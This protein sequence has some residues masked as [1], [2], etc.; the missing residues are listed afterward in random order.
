[1]IRLTLVSNALHLEAARRLHQLAVAAD[2]SDGARVDLLIWEPRRM[3]LNAEDRR[4]WPLRLPVGSLVLAV[5]VPVALAGKVG[6]MRLPHLRHAGRALRLIAAH[7]RQLVLIDDGL[8][9]YRGI[10]KA[11]APDHFP[12]GTAY[13]LFSDAP[14]AR[15]S[16]C[17]RFSCRELGP[18]YPAADPRQQGDPSAAGTMIIDAPGVERLVAVAEQLPRPWLVATHP[19][20]SKRSWPLTRTA[21]TAVAT[22]PPE[23]LIPDF[24][25]LIVVGESMTLLAA[26]RLRR[27]G[28]RILIALPQDVDAHLARLAA[29]LAAGDPGIRLL[30]PER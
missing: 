16:W 12:A 28:T 20:R 6:E 13:W 21:G 9:Q 24:A 2:C 14:E 1:M 22:Q 11:V 15:A 10:P 3:R 23:R 18:L 8:D 7:S 30:P 17:A 25:G 27:P 5:L 29:R 4:R 26:I 19:V